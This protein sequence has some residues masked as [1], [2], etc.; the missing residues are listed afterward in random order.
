[1]QV[2][3]EAT[4]ITTDHLNDV[5]ALVSQFE[6]LDLRLQGIFLDRVKESFDQQREARKAALLAELAALGVDAPVRQAAAATGKRTRVVKPSNV[7]YRSKTDP[8]MSWV[9]R[10][11]KPRWLIEE[12]DATGLPKEA[13][14][15]QPVAA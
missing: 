8:V 1:M 14:L 6:G 10:G 13:F 9:G 7:L 2:N 11:K 4:V 15:D 5:D 12:M 3:G